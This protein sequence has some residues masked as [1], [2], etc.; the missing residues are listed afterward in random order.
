M[1]AASKAA[2][3]RVS[4]YQPRQRRARRRSRLGLFPQERARAVSSSW[5]NY[6]TRS[7]YQPRQRARLGRCLRINESGC[8]RRQTISAATGTA[9]A[10]S[11]STAG[12]L[13]AASGTPSAPRFILSATA[14][15]KDQRRAR[16][17]LGLFAAGHG[18]RAYS[19]ERL[20]RGRALGSAVWRRSRVR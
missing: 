20:T 12:K 2:A 6:Q 15:A 9:G 17:G 4:S 8:K 13:F 5:A 7:N 16:L 3:R 1:F 10:V 14:T 11:S 18:P 19:R